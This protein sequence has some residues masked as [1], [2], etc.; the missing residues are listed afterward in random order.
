MEGG[1]GRRAN[2]TSRL[3]LGE[4]SSALNYGQGRSVE[5]PKSSCL[6]GDRQREVRERMES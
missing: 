5:R 6:A 3:T 1:G 4:A 2:A